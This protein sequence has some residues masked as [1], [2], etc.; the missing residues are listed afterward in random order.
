MLAA[1][2][3]GGSSSGKTNP[4]AFATDAISGGDTAGPVATLTVTP[5]SVDIGT[6]DVGAKSAPMTVTVANVSTVSSGPL[7]VTVSGTGI[8]ATGCSGT[9]LA[10][11]ATCTITVTA[12]MAVAGQISGTIEVGDT[13]ANTKKISVSGNSV[14]PGQY[15]LAPTP[16][17]LGYV[18][19]GKPATGTVVM[20]NNAPTGLTGIL[21]NISGTGFSAGAGTC[22]ESL[23]VGQT[24]NIVVNFTAGNTSGA[25]KGSLTVNQGSVTKVVALSATV[26]TPAKLVM[27]P[28]SASF[29][30]VLGTP[31][32]PVTFYVTNAGDVTSAIP[33][34]TITGTNKDDFSQTSSCATALAGGATASCQI[35][36]IYNPKA[37][38]TTS[39]T[40]TL[41]VAEPG[42]AGSS[43]TATLTGT[44]VPPSDLVISG[45]VTDFGTV[46]VGTTSA[47]LTFTLTNRGGDDAGIVKLSTAAPFSFVSDTCTDKSLAAKATCT[48]T[49]QFKPTEGDSLPMQGQFKAVGANVANPALFSVTGTAVPQ[50]KLA[51]NPASLEFGALPTYQ[52][53]TP[54]TLTISN[55]GAAP[56]GVLK[57]ENTGAQFKVKGDT[58]TGASLTAAGAT[59]TCTIIVTFTSANTDMD[60]TGSI[61]VTDTTGAAGSVSASLHGVGTDHAALTFTPGIV[62]PQY[63]E[64]DPFCVVSSSTHRLKNKVIGQTTTEM[65]FT[66]KNSTSP[67]V[68]PDSG[69]L[70]FTIEGAAATDFAIV[71]NNCTAPLVSTGDP[72]NPTT[73]V[74]TLTFKPSAAG[75]RKALLKVSSSR[76]GAAQATLEGKGLPVL[77]IQPTQVTL[78][79]TGLEFGQVALGHNDPALNSHPYRIWVRE[80]TSA[81]RNTTVTVA[82][83][84]PNPAD[85]V[86]PT[87]PAALTVVNGAN[88]DGIGLLTPPI[89]LGE[90]TSN[91]L[92]NPCD[93]KTV[94]LTVGPDKLPTSAT[95]AGNSPYVYDD[96]SGYW[97]CDFGV[98]FY[99]Q[100]ARG[101]LTAALSGSASGGGS[102]SVTLTGTAS[103]PLVINP[104]PALLQDPVSVGMSSSTYLTLTVKNDGAVNQNGLTFALSGTGAGDFQIVGTD[105]WGTAAAYSPAHLYTDLKAVV[106]APAAS[107]KVWLGFQPKTEGPYSVTFTAT[108]ANAAGAA[109]DEVATDTIIANGSLVFGAITVAPNPGTAAFADTPFKKTDAAPVTFTIRN[110]GTK[111]ATH[112]TYSVLNADFTILPS[113]GVAGACSTADS[114]VLA[115]G[116]SCTIQVRPTPTGNPAGI[117]KKL[118]TGTLTID[119]TP[120]GSVLVP[121]SYY[122][123][124][125]IMLVEAGAAVSSVSYT[126]AP[127][128]LLSNVDHSFVVS[129]TG[130]SAV[131]LANTTASP[132]VVLDSVAGLT[133]PVCTFGTNTLAAGGTCTL[134]VRN[135]NSAVGV[136]SPESPV[137]ITVSD[138]T[139]PT[140]NATVRLSATTLTAS[141][142][143]TYGLVDTSGSPIDLGTVPIDSSTATFT[144]GKATVWF[145]NVGQVATKA[146]TF[147]WDLQLPAPATTG[148]AGTADPEFIIDSDET[149]CV[150]KA[151][152]PKA[153]CSMSIH[154]KPNTTQRATLAARTIKLVLVDSDPTLAPV[155]YFTATPTAS[156]SVYVED[157]TGARDGFFQFTQTTPTTP[158]VTE[159]VRTFRITNASGSSQTVAPVT[160]GVFTVDTVAPSN[161]CGASKAL[162]TGESCQFNVAFRPTSATNVFQ[163]GTIA[164]F[165][166]TVLGLMGRV[167]QPVTLEIQQPVTSGSCG[168]DCV[169][170]GIV[171][172]GGTK[173]QSLT[174]VNLGDVPMDSSPA[175]L[176]VG[177]TAGLA[178]AGFTY[179]GADLCAGVRLKAYGTT[180]DRCVVTVTATGVSLARTTPSTA[181][182]NVGTGAPTTA[183][184]A[185]YTMSAKVYLG[186]N[187][188]V[189]GDNVFPNTAVTSYSEKTYTI[190]NGDNANDYIPTGVVTASLTGAQADQ[191]VVVGNSC[192]PNVGL[193]SGASCQVTVRFMPKTLSSSGNAFTATLNVAATPGGPKTATLQGT[194]KS[195]LTI[196]PPGAGPAVPATLTMGSVT[197]AFRIT[198]DANAVATSPV[199]TSIT[200]TDFMLV[201]DRCY[202]QILSG[203]GNKATCDVSV[204]Y[205]GRS[206]SSAKTATITVNGGSEGQSVAIIVSYTGAEAASH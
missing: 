2:G 115:G 16:L 181:T 134:V 84:K 178:G 70:T 204:K 141:S 12:Q 27:A 147:R 169:D 60:A 91:S 183:P 192:P 158:P 51:I 57:V 106:L 154:F 129:N 190:T 137:V 153:F 202:G 149:S 142:L 111:D 180:G 94:S 199:T 93:N 126:F 6:I 165:A 20:T 160:S 122:E 124:S 33:T 173:A 144:G 140:N 78:T 172:V 191:F 132:F 198:K 136:I 188:L 76:G 105:C 135:T 109:D 56:T 59:K 206:T 101:A 81:D 52:E 193:T 123:T 161:P 86:W 120:G 42:T 184:T 116:A 62:C 30:T 74:L 175:G 96:A 73:C 19:A 85:F 87:S 88:A 108:A 102:S 14:V 131:S 99:P 159:E 69:A 168:T 185:T 98:Q 203:N 146:L 22:T 127:A 28:K 148:I 46:I 176:V 82:L 11:K 143:Q 89:D 130:S 79:H 197:Q 189:T 25:A 61:V 40:A 194:P 31:S 107:C 157:V 182:L 41:T 118:V 177:V 166:G 7:G 195:A 196:D 35:T 54:Q 97:Y 125:N 58:C 104:S 145:R 55:T 26:Q 21:I 64:D 90:F 119:S 92:T 179:T 67:T 13:A 50:A 45:A 68:A 167:Q 156:A 49:A 133:P 32:T 114:F 113:V 186:A 8:T 205:I 24:C 72:A 150:N 139:T 23:G 47:P 38:P 53:S 174:V 66:L 5:P 3:C 1:A 18:L 117:G 10:P 155:V 128:G 171:G 95:Q 39:S 63:Q 170:F 151:L 65:A 103:G 17:D 200:G 9:T 15:S 163:Y 138:S 34:V 201:D 110:T 80:T 164:P 29:Q 83:P 112:L 71:Q 44:A 36:V 4:D 121:L 43:D 187:A 37:A 77:E 48:F 162:A 152:A 100:S 75:L